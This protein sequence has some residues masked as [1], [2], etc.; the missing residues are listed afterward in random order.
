MALIFLRTMYLVTGSHGMN[1]GECDHMFGM[2]CNE[3]V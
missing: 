1:C 2:K 3:H